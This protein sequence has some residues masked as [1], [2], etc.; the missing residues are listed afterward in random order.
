MWV[1]N[2]LG[3]YLFLLRCARRD[4]SAYLVDF[5]IAD[6]AFSE[7]GHRPSAAAHKSFDNGGCQVFALFQ[8]CWL[9]ALIFD[10]QRVGA[11]QHGA[12]KVALVCP[13]AGG[14][15]P[16]EKL[17]STCNGSGGFGCVGNWRCEQR[18]QEE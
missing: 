16:G 17:F 14:A 6:L 3:S 7:W 9:L 1:R 18:E 4:V 15:M 8:Q 5:L 13:V 12:P 10:S 2:C 11:W